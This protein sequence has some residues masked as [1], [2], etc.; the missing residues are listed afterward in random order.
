L[1]NPFLLIGLFNK[2]YNTSLIPLPRYPCPIPVLLYLLQDN[3]SEE[4]KREGAAIESGLR[5]L[6]DRSNSM[7]GKG[8]FI[9]M[10]S[11]YDEDETDYLLSC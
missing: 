2:R 1:R 7:I 5:W 9:E 8:G 6:E 3:R 4:N 10:T 11:Q